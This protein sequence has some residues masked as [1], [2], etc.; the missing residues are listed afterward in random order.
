MIK[1]DIQCKDYDE[2]KIVFLNGRFQLM[3]EY[4]TDFGVKNLR[5]PTNDE[6]IAYARCMNSL[7][8]S[9]GI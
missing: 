1:R 8:S 7:T 3:I 2:A 5:K 4:C 9:I 6:K